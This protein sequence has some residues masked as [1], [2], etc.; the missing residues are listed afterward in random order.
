MQAVLSQTNLDNALDDF[1]KKDVKYYYVWEVTAE[2]R[3]KVSM[4]STHDN[5]A[6]MMTKPIYVA[7]FEL[8]SSSVDITI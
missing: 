3:L 5:L 8:C 4:I 7:K 1:G 6:D 2:A